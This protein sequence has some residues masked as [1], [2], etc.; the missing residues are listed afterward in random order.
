MIS[1]CYKIIKLHAFWSFDNPANILTALPGA[2]GP[3]AKQK[4]FALPYR[5]PLWRVP[6]ATRGDS[7]MIGGR[8]TKKCPSIARFRF[9]NIRPFLVRS[10]KGRLFVALVHRPATIRTRPSSAPPV[11]SGPASTPSPSAP[12]TRPKSPYVDLPGLWRQQ[13]GGELCYL[14]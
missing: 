12:T 8:C 7:A 13:E 5:E 3:S 2:T 1:F 11:I 10:R 4:D 14:A 9:L 6:D